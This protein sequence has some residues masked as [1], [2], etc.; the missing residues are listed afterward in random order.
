MPEEKRD[1]RTS[2][3]LISEL[4]IANHNLTSC[5]RRMQESGRTEEMN[6][7]Y[8]L[9]EEHFESVKKELFRRLD[10]YERC[11]K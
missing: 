7:L 10:F 3:E 1:R 2:E 6:E 11:Q 5:L 9:F 8:K 4:L